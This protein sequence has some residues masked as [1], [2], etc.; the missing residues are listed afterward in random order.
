MF[1]KILAVIFF[2]TNQTVLAQI[3]FQK[4]YGGTSLEFGYCVQ[5]T[6]DSGYIIG[7]ITGSFGAGGDIYLIK[8]NFTG[9]TLW[10]RTFGG[11]DE[12]EC[13][14][15]RQTTDGGYILAGTTKSFGA[16]YYDVY[17]LK[18]D[19]SGNLLWSKTYGGT[20]A[21]YAKSIQQ[22][23]D[24][25]YIIFG[26]TA[27][28]GAGG[29]GAFDMYLIK[30]NSN[31]DSLWTRTFGGT[32]PDYGMAGQQTTDSG[33]IIAGGVDYVNLIKTNI[34]GDTLWTK[35]IHPSGTGGF[36]N[37]AQQT[38]DGGYIIT[39]Y[40][41]TLSLFLT[42]TDSIGNPLWTK[43]FD[44]GTSTIGHSVQQTL[45]GGFIIVGGSWAPST[46]NIIILIK[47]N[48]A[49]DTLWTNTYS[50]LF[51]ARKCS[52]QQTFDGG[53]IISS[54]KYVG[55]VG[56]HDILLIKTDS[57][58]NSGCNQMNN[59]IT[60]T[61]ATT[62]TN[63]FNITVASGGIIAPSAP[64]VG[65]GGTVTTL[66]TIVGIPSEIQNP[67]SEISISPNPFHSTTVLKLSDDFSSSD[68]TLE[69]FNVD[70]K[71]I[72]K[73]PITSHETVIERNGLSPG[74][75]FY[76]LTSGITAKAFGKLIIQ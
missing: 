13:N 44:I 17:I 31:G 63:N 65:S 60:I 5:Q 12:D 70:G 53:Y 59:V 42:K 14:S 71:T 20:S 29:P 76:K 28:Y 21:D 66:C 46:Q 30:T 15:V 41:D 43:L 36:V 73:L 38:A 25:G 2:L 10:T 57:F 6:T 22:T 49:G 58:G 11:A 68:L 19:S 61:I 23:S 8:T 62:L 56:Y 32:W 24:G 50:G 3:T 34:N 69:I 55:G 39:G 52:V 18:T 64:L 9:D 47:T 16:G 7:G 67:Q 37:S 27:S 26:Y 1:K 45:D 4:T 33:F 51:D 74:I 72:R 54:G 40:T 75:Y 35:Y 48:I